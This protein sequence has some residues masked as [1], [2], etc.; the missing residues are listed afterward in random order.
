[1]KLAYSPYQEVCD[2][3]QLNYNLNVNISGGVSPYVVS[4]FP[5]SLP[6]TSSISIPSSTWIPQENKYVMSVTDGCNQ[7]VQ[8]DTIVLMN[9]CPLS[10]P[11]VI[12]TNLDQTNEFFIVKN[13][14]DF[15]EVSLLVVNRWGNVVYENNS[16]KNE[17][18]GLDQSGK[19]LSEGVYFYV[20][21]TTDD[22]YVYN[23]KEALKYS[24]NGFVHIVRTQE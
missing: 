2:E 8:T 20:I 24:L 6:S 7:E 3:A 21:K 4:W 9:Q 16:Y 15:D 18:S 22:R 17:W 19:P 1:M 10:P 23:E 14:E 12:T 13:L 5:S 11:N